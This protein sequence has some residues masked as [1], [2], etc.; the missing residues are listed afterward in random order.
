MEN[1]R[2][3]V[4]ALRRVGPSPHALVEVDAAASCARCEQGKG[5]GAGLLGGNRGSRRVDARISSGL[6]IRE[7]DEVSIEL[8]P[9]NLLH[10]SLIVYGFPLSGAILGAACAYFFSLGEL[11]AAMAALGGIVA[12]VLAARIRLRA[13]GCLRRFT[14]EIVGR[15][16]VEQLP[17]G[18]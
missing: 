7:G 9:A 5:C 17:G 1:P 18:L 11:Y 12:G 14:P 13:S 16:S 4:I 2:G 10:A 6:D 3:R 15:L 8:A